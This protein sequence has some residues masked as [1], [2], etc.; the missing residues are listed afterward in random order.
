M[1]RASQRKPQATRQQPKRH[2]KSD[3]LDIDSMIDVHVQYS[4]SGEEEGEGEGEGE[5]EERKEGVCLHDLLHLFHTTLVIHNFTLP[6]GVNTTIEPLPQSLCTDKIASCVS[7]TSKFTLMVLPVLL[8][9]G[10][11]RLMP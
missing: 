2:D 8:V 9:K 10:S 4:G 3:S 5:G 6:S 1:P 11:L 7:V